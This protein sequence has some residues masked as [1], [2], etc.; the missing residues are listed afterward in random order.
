MAATPDGDG[1]WLVGVRRWHLPFGDAGFYGSTGGMHLNQPVVGMAATP[2]GGGYWLVASDGG[3]FAFGDAGFYGSMGGTPQPAHR[4]HG[5]RRRAGGYWLVASDGE[6]FTFGAPFYGSLGVAPPSAP[7]AALAPTIDNNGYWLVSQSG[8]VYGFGNA[9]QNGSLT[10]WPSPATS[11]VSSPTGGYWILTA[12]GVVHPLGIS[13][14]SPTTTPEHLPGRTKHDELGHVGLPQR[15]PRHHDELRLCST[16][17]SF[18]RVGRRR[19]P[20]H[21]HGLR[22]RGGDGRLLRHEYLFRLFGGL[23]HVDHRYSPGWNRNGRRSGGHA[24]R[25]DRGDRQR[26]VHLRADQPAPHHGVGRPASKS[27]ACRTRSPA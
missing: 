17:N 13:A 19:R 3:I 11:I 1:Y 24:G 4:R 7:I 8:T 6:V 23:T 25:R 5:A 22:I 2:D 14:S 10:G 21:R 15:L 18:E 12:D 26:P 20:H 27:A 9:G 16:T